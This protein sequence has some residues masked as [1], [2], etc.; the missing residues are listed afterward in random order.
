MLMAYRSRVDDDGSDGTFRGFLIVYLGFSVEEVFMGKG[1]TSGEPCGPHTMSPRGQRR[2][3]PPRG[4]GALWLPSFS[5]LDYVY[6][7]VI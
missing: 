4:V 7:T 3:A 5:P 1:A 2:G 6:V